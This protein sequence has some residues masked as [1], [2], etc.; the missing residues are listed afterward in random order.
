VF[1]A[2][3]IKVETS[4]KV[5]ALEY[6]YPG[7]QPTAAK[8][9]LKIR[10]VAQPIYFTPKPQPS[11]MSVLTNP[12]VMLMLGMLGLTFCMPSASSQSKFLAKHVPDDRNSLPGVC[13]CV[14]PGVVS[15]VT[16]AGVACAFVCV[17]HCAGKEEKE[18]MQQQMESMG[19]GA[20]GAPDIS[21]MMSKLMGGGR[22]GDVSD[23]ED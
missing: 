18:Q 23:D 12:Q 7:A 16:F 10:H 6:A 3:K 1:P 5:R 15:L 20:G 21:S 2:F 11:I 19:M 8:V 22:G 9:P 17:Y 4:G 14:R 13:L